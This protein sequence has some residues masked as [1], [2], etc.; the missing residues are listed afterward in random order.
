MDNLLR[1][2]YIETGLEQEEEEE[3]ALLLPNV[4]LGHYSILNSHNQ[5]IVVYLQ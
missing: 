4:D 3:D 2:V 5:I 1:I